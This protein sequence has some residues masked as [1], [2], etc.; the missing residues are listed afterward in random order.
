M[1]PE[2][3]YYFQ[4]T[5]RVLAAAICGSWLIWFPIYKLIEAEDTK[6]GA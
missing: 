5:I 4:E 1:S 2:N 6:R 3:W